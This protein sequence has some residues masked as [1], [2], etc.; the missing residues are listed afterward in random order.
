M[1]LSTVERRQEIMERREVESNT[2]TE[3]G[4]SVS[5]L[6]AVCAVCNV[7]FVIR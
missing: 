6:T 7:V 4:V 5:P 2:T 1:G 3:M